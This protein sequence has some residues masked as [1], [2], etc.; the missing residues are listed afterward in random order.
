MRSLSESTAIGVDKPL[1]A[2]PLPTPVSIVLMIPP[3][4]RSIINNTALLLTLS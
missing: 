3:V 2:V 1:G 4:S